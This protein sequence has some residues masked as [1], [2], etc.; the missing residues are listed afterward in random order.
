MLL[1]LILIDNIL[2]KFELARGLGVLDLGAMLALLDG[3]LLVELLGYL[4]GPIGQL[5]AVSRLLVWVALDVVA[6]DADC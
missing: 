1:I 4:H 2:L 5:E 6:Q 3:Y